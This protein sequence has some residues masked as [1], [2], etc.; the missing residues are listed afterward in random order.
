ML[1]KF[2]VTFDPES[3][4]TPMDPF[5]G[6]VD[7]GVFRVFRS[8]EHSLSSFSSRTSRIARVV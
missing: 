1:T 3:G 8:K 7:Q 6:Y 5:P 4:L 2:W